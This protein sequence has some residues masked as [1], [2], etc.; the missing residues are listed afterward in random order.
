MSRKDRTASQATS[1]EDRLPMDLGELGR[2]VL[3]AMPD[4]C[5]IADTR[6]QVVYANP[7]YTRVCY[8]DVR[9][10]VGDNIFRNNPEG[11]LAQALRSGQ[12][13]LGKKYRVYGGPVEIVSH[14]FPL[15][16]NGIMVGAVAF[17]REMSPALELLVDLEREQ[18]TVRLLQARLEAVGRTGCTFE[19]LVGTSAAMVH[20]L[21]VAR[22]AAL[23]NAPV[24]LQGEV[25]TGKT[26]LAQAIHSA[27]RR[28]KE[29][30]LTI[31]CGTLAPDALEDMLFGGADE[32]GQFSLL[33]VAGGGTIFLDQVAELPKESQLRLLEVFR[34]E[35]WQ[36][37]QKTDGPAIIAATNGRLEEMVAK[38]SF[39]EELYHY[40]RAVTIEIPPLRERLEDLPALVEHLLAR[41]SRSLDKAVAGLD[42]EVL[43]VFRS[44]SWPGNVRELANVLERAVML[45]EDRGW[46]TTR[47]VFIPQDLGEAPEELILPLEEMEQ[48]MISRALRKYGTSVAGK[49]EAAKALNISLTTLYNK[50]RRGGAFSGLDPYRFSRSGKG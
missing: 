17:F 20:V 9:Q 1:L 11:A 33:E 46:I 18:R 35:R 4:A 28:R 22:R 39:L 13:A 37:K 5:V 49:R 10:L 16:R 31:P 2:A 6:G 14:A 24:L 40:L 3:D 30:F 8:R 42:G 50:L 36:E 25:G 12:P 29:P 26:S 45:V 19:D 27:S 15:F 23:S 48:I 38:G 47:H 34:G 21:T 44:Y 7:A 32:A 41:F 43:A